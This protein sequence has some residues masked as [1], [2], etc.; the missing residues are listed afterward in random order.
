MYSAATLSGR[1]VF[2]REAAVTIARKLGAEVTERRNHAVAVV[3]VNGTF[4]GSY[5]IRRGSKET[6]HNYIPA[7]IGVTTKEAL[8]I[9]LCDLYLQDYVARLQDSG[10]LPAA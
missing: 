2:T 4:I 3:R 8:G 1:K 6:S 10:R 5:G 7:Q 9:A